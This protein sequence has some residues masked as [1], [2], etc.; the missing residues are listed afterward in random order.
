MLKPTTTQEPINSRARHTTQIP[1][2][3]RNVALSLNIQAAQSHTKPLTSQN[4]LLDTSLHSR[5]K[6]SSSTHQNTDTASLA[7]KPRQVTCPTLPTVRNLHNK[8]EPP[9]ARI[10]KGHP[11]HSNINQMKRQRNTQQ[12]KEQDKCPQNQT[13]EEERGNLPDKEFR[14]MIVK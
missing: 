13:K 4:S 3:H 2:Q 14:I 12:V 6:K 11:K 1:Q 10:Q 8:E 9:A 7:R 5:E